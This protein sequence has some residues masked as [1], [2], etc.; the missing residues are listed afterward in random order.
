MA[1]ASACCT[2]LNT[3][4]RALQAL[5]HLRRAFGFLRQ[6][7][8][9]L[10]QFSLE[11]KIRKILKIQNQIIRIHSFLHQ[12]L[13]Y[14]TSFISHPRPVMRPFLFFS[15]C[16]CFFFCFLPF[17]SVPSYSN[18]WQGVPKYSNHA[19]SLFST[20]GGK[21]NGRKRALAATH[22]SSEFP[23]LSLSIAAADV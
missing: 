10:R 22:R 16:F 21:R 5:D 17:L 11:E 23:A 8:Q 19:P 12:D 3:F 1:I 4:R 9:R 14:S 7:L 6:L 13:Q 18:C 15:F 20:V 2:Y